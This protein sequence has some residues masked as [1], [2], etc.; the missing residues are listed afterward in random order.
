MNT[1]FL[2]P[3]HKIIEE[4]SAKQREKAAIKVENQI[5]TY[6]KLNNYANYIAEMLIKAG[7]GIDSIVGIVMG[8]TKELPIAIY[9]VHKAGC[10]YAPMD[11][12]CSRET[13]EAI[14]EDTK[15]HI[16]LTTKHLRHL[17][18]YSY[19]GM[20]IELDEILESSMHNVKEISADTPMDTIA[21]IMPTSGSTGR[22]KG[23]MVKNIGLSNYLYWAAEYYC[24]GE[25][26]NFPIYSSISF[27][28][29]I[30]SIY[31]PLI[32]G[33]TIYPMH[34]KTVIEAANH[35]EVNFLKLTPAHLSI[36][37]NLDCSNSKVKKIIVGGEGLKTQ[38]ALKAYER[39]GRDIM[40][41]NEYG[42]T[43][44]TV[45]SMIKKFCPEEKYPSV[46][47]GKAINNTAIY[48]LDNNMKLVSRGSIGEIFIS[49]DG[50]AKG[51]LNRNEETE[52]CFLPNPFITGQYM[53]RTGDLGRVLQNG[54]LEYMGRIQTPET[55]LVIDGIDIRVDYIENTALS[56]SGIE[57]AVIVAKRNDENKPYLALYYLSQTQVVEDAL[58]I[59]LETKLQKTIIPNVIKRLD[60][61][62]LNYNGKVFRPSLRAIKD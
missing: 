14:I 42:P 7:C 58:R 23:V 29:T 10:T 18:P 54:D 21:Y 56:Y 41:Y 33:G 47:I 38:I 13:I 28:L 48:L 30:T 25:K 24:M 45:G 9:A 55:G 32:T 57:E 6:D 26:A 17:I 49:G 59:F 51:Y 60:S 62:P 16:I 1:A 8:R 19:T 36:L 15:A 31:L 22:P 53:Y 43:E 12:G 61:I 3:I 52:E 40:I 37:K 35:Q 20:V 46:S 11:S 39:F 44:T 5:I 27:D 4:K 2:K 50:V 34:E